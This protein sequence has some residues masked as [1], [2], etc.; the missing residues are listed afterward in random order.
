LFPRRRNAR[1]ARARARPLVR[2][3]P[4]RTGLDDYP[5]N[6]S[7]ADRCGSAWPLAGGRW[8]TGPTSFCLRRTPWAAPW[9][10]AAEP[11][12]P[13]NAC[14][15]YS[16]VKLVRGPTGPGVL[17]WCW[18]QHDGRRRRISCSVPRSL[19]CS[20]SPPAVW[21]IPV[22]HDF[23]Y[24]TQHATEMSRSLSASR[25]FPWEVKQ[26]WPVVSKNFRCGKPV[27]TMAALTSIKFPTEN[28]THQPFFLPCGRC[29]GKGRSL[30]NTEPSTKRYRPG[31]VVWGMAAFRGH[32]FRWNKS[33]I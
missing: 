4:R 12:F 1:D 24:R 6:L 9:M 33:R 3:G 23:N 14:G 25:I 11:Q 15:S 18:S 31:P 17:G 5:R 10:P 19:L 20:I 29:V 30:F 32:F 8:F 21:R 16:F 7:G 26:E 13:R 27:R 28:T 22:D 2:C